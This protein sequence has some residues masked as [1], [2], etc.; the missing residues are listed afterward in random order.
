MER[1]DDAPSE[2]DPQQTTEACARPRPSLA[3]HATPLTPGL[4]H[5]MGDRTA[6]FREHRGLFEKYALPSLRKSRGYKGAES[7][8]S[9]VLLLGDRL[10][11][12]FGTHEECGSIAQIPGV[13]A[14]M[15]RL[16]SEGR[17]LGPEIERH[18]RV[19][20]TWL[21]AVVYTLDPQEFE[22][23]EQRYKQERRERK[24][25]H[26]APHNHH[27]LILLLE[28]L[29]EAEAKKASS[30]DDLHQLRDPVH[31]SI[32][33]AKLIGHKAVGHP[34]PLTADETALLPQAFLISVL[35]P[36][37][38]HEKSLRDRL[39]GI[40][41]HP[42]MLQPV[43]TRLK[44]TEEWRQ[45]H[46][47]TFSARQD[48]LKKLRGLVRRDPQSPGQYILLHGPEGSGKS[49]L[50]AKLSEELAAASQ[51]LGA[52]PQGPGD[53][54]PWLPGC[55]L[56]EG[57]RSD[58]I[59]GLRDALDAQANASLLCA[60]P[61][62]GPRAPLETH[63]RGG[64]PELESSSPEKVEDHSRR[65]LRDLFAQLAEQRGS[66]VVILDGLDEFSPDGAELGVLP[67]EAS[68]GSTILLSARTG[69]PAHL[70]VERNLPVRALQ[71]SPVSREEI[72]LLT[73]IPDDSDPLAEEWNDRVF[74]VGKGWVLAAVES[75]R[76]A[77]RRRGDFA[78][79]E[80]LDGLTQVHAAQANRWSAHADPAMRK[81]SETILK[82]LVL[83]HSAGGLTLTDLQRLLQC[84]GITVSLPDMKRLLRPLG[85]QMIG[86]E[87]DRPRLAHQS[88][89]DYVL[90]SHYGGADWEHL[91]T[92]VGP[93]FTMG[94]ASDRDAVPT[95]LFG[96]GF[97]T[98]IMLHSDRAAL[99]EALFKSILA[100]GREVDIHAFCRWRPWSSEVC[101]ALIWAKDAKLASICVV[102]LIMDHEEENLW[103]RVPIPMPESLL[104]RAV[105]AGNL[106]AMLLKAEVL[107]SRA[108]GIQIEFEG[109]APTDGR[110]VS[111][112]E[113]RALELIDACVEGGH[114]YATALKAS[115]LIDAGEYIEAFKYFRASVESPAFRDYGLYSPDAGY[116]LDEPFFPQMSSMCEGFRLRKDLPIEMRA[117]CDT[118]FTVER[119]D[120]QS[121]W[122]FCSEV[123]HAEIS[124]DGLDDY[125]MV[126]NAG[127]L[128]AQ[129]LAGLTL[130]RHSLD[131]HSDLAWLR[132][133][134][135]SIAPECHYD[136]D[137]GL[138]LLRSAAD[139]GLPHA[140]HLLG[141]VLIDGIN[142][143]HDLAEGE[144][145][146]RRASQRG[147]EQA[148]TELGIRL[149][150]GIGLPLNPDAGHAVFGPL[151]GSTAD[152]QL[153]G[154]WLKGAPMLEYA[155]C[156]LYGPAPCHDPALGEKVLRDL[157]EKPACFSGEFD[158]GQ[159]RAM[160]LLLSWLRGSA[161]RDDDAEELLQRA[162]RAGHGDAALEVAIRKY[163]HRTIEGGDAI[164]DVMQLLD[165][166][167][168]RHSGCR[169][170]YFGLVR[171][172]ELELS[173]DGE[174]WILAVLDNVVR[175]DDPW[176]RM[177]LALS[178]ASGF[179][180]A[181]SLSDAT[182]TEMLALGVAPEVNWKAADATVS[183]ITDAQELLKL[184]G[185][186]AEGNHPEGHLV[187]G[188]L[189]R[190][191]LIEDPS[192]LTQR[193]RLERARQGGWD[194]PDWLFEPA[195]PPPELA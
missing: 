127:G 32:L 62:D 122:D 98:Q 159:L 11:A 104:D 136:F 29:P 119:L 128:C 141:S 45:Y 181:K 89:A 22:N 56:Y 168:K 140:M 125:V 115:L 151:R 33:A 3:S 63:R 103:E 18:L 106:D 99:L 36:L 139:R 77:H 132:L 101:P 133:W 129:Y 64:K 138:K 84:A 180:F 178:L 112:M 38:R 188:L 52:S 150:R 73:G 124:V 57:R 2:G 113:R 193:D 184:W 51:S 21:K 190:H 185:V 49:A 142:V 191:G 93:W 10:L 163:L 82:L 19:I 164:A 31:R 16:D 5:T 143:D 155:K 79:V 30:V 65:H 66:A 105:E 165:E 114:F 1:W 153:D 116:G 135:R 147:H 171:W 162:A 182:Q 137:G 152:W 70:W 68:A 61:Y 111:A 107:R 174:E 179:A 43:A 88:L 71:L 118:L 24:Q 146:L 189:E 39:A 44:D 25:T 74:E 85:D 158:N 15:A 161:G 87:A 60:T 160:S 121:C 144:E 97:L 131:L 81:C 53:L 34:R 167:E 120:E 123:Q 86:S 12:A 145:W 28:L 54:A 7:R 166:P 148:A 69:S 102:Q 27:G 187:L 183:S 108:S 4:G 80:P 96:S 92:L 78:G 13:L 9:A 110:D 72:P 109:T 91:L 40:V 41:I 173:E 26:F 50:C 37:M 17:Q 195:P 46:L 59:D 176:F 117:Y 100:N 90:Q 83:W 58:G 149:L 47:R 130:A 170:L 14:E 75:G 94:P 55:L 186:L 192:G 95:L 35:A 194:V 177:S 23:R 42:E 134:P 8:L 157:F 154:S 126:A 175:G 67:R 172:G 48:W 6:T 169:A 20:E 76:E 156:L